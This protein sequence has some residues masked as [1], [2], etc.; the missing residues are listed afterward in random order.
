MNAP[1]SFIIENKEN[2]LELNQKVLEIIEKSE[3]PQ[4]FLFYGKTR[5]GKSTTLNQLIKGN[6]ESRKFRNTKPFKSNDT[7]DSVTK[8]CNIYGPIKA[9]EL[10]KKHSLKKKLKKDYDVFFCDT[11]GI[12]SLDG[13]KRESIPGI[14]TLLQ[15]SKISV[16]MVQKNCNADDVKEI[17]SQIELSRCLKQINNENNK[18]KENPEF[19]TPTI[20]VYISSIFIGSKDNNNYEKNDEEEDENDYDSSAIKSKYKESK[21]IEKQR[22]YNAVNEKY[23]DL[24]LKITD[25]DVIPG[26]PYIDTNKEPS[27]DDIDAELYWWSINELMSKF[28]NA[29]RKKMNSKDV[30]DMIKFLFEIFQ[31]VKSL[32]GDFNLERFLKNYLKE[33]FEE[34]STKKFKEKIERIKDD[35]KINFN[36]Y[37][38]IINDVE[39][40]K[41]SLN[42]CFDQNINLYKRLIGDKIQNFIELSVEQ[43][44]KHIKEQIDKEFQSICDNIL[45]NENI[46]LLIKDVVEMINKAEF[47]EDVD[48]NI[49]NNVNVFW[50]SMYEKNKLILDYFKTRKAG[51]LDNLKENFIAQINKIFLNLLNK[52]ILWANFSKD[53]LINIQKEINK[54]YIEY[55]NKCQYQ[56]DIEVFIIKPNNFYKEVFPL[57]QEKYFKN[58]SENKLNEIKEKVKK[59]CQN[60]Y[61]KVIKNKLPI[62]KDIKLDLI[63]R[64]QKSIETYLFKIFNGKKFRDE[65]E[66]NLGRKDI[67]MNM[68]P[69]N[70]KEN[71][72]IK[73][74]KKKE[75]LD[76]IE[77]EVEKGVINFNNLREKLPLLKE[78]ISNKI[79][80]CTE[81]INKRMKELLQQFYYIEEKIIFN[82]D[83]IFAFLTKNGN[84]FQNS[85]SKL[86]EINEKIKELCDSKA[87]EYDL[88]VVKFKP[89]WNKIKSEKIKFIKEKCQNF[90]SNLFQ[91]AHFQDNIKS[92]DMNNLRNEIIQTP[93]FYQGVSPNKKNEINEEINKILQITEERIL[94]RKNGLQ[95][96]DA[97]K[98]QK[99]QQ[100]F[101]EMTN[102]SKTDIN[103]LNLNEITEKLVEHVEMIP[104][105]FDFCK[106]SERKKEVLE[107]IRINA[108]Q[109]A[110]DYLNKKKAEIQ[111]NKQH[112]EITKNLQNMIK[113]EEK[114]VKDEEKRRIYVERQAQEQ[115]R[116]LE[117]N[118]RLRKQENEQR[119]KEVAQ[120]RKALEEEKR[121]R[122]EEEK[123]RRE[124]EERRR[125]EEADRIRRQNEERI[126]IQ[127]EENRRREEHRLFIED[128]ARRAMN[129]QFGNGQARRNALGGNYAEVQNK[130]NEW[131]GLPK[132]Y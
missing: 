17:C 60:E 53:L 31:G 64:V 26:G 110:Q 120:L 1:L 11:E 73:N 18:N 96:W 76:I 49:V 100:A 93:N 80:I 105:F 117:E 115:A 25:F 44:Q 84:I 103:S 21:D 118:E 68:I 129:G 99:V 130:I 57:F 109:I 54:N 37:L 108:K 90:T 40:A 77:K 2:K 121:R 116:R 51:I 66:P 113:I 88:L 82:S 65:V 81:I 69:A 85:G 34:Y 119:N 97:I 91:N 12:S 92:I 52:K 13:I 98:L 45:S 41:K 61:E 63:S 123:R 75:I 106:G 112:E 59:I 27:E 9:S 15:I 36:Q 101:I 3:N 79:N 107:E 125:R 89:E 114:R 32:G 127:N 39:K 56:E 122:E 67:I 33:K 70:I 128:L 86:S 46:N 10:I 50:E 72:L 28:I 24:N 131:L 42:E 124:E 87:K 19:P 55:F 5:L 71:S 111:K 23:P 4:F 83:T 8:G 78:S 30:I 22:I 6:L 104:K 102:K 20:T 38:D 35:I 74:D 43:Y 95:N 47:K 29:E 62:W 94:S 7:L 58:I 126:R 16:F 48:M 132:R 14:L